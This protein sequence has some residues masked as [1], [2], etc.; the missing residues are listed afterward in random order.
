V[1]ANLILGQHSELET[2]P[3]AQRESRN[4]E[5]EPLRWLAVRYAQRALLRIDE[6]AENGLPRPLDAPLAEF[7]AKH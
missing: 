5:P 3:I 4:W 6:A 2:L 1:L 7:L